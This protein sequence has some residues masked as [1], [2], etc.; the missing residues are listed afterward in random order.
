M[1]LF[2]GISISGLKQH[3]SAQLE[4]IRNNTN[5]Q[6][7]RKMSANTLA[8]FP[9]C[10]TNPN[11]QQCVK[12]QSSRVAWIVAALALCYAYVLPF[13]FPVK[14]VVEVVKRTILIK[15][16]FY[17]YVLL[18]KSYK[19]TIEIYLENSYYLGKHQRSAPRRQ[20]FTS[21]AFCLR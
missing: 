12:Q 6:L 4:P 21:C 20:S 2:S 18:L 16:I 14:I 1:K 5:H 15:H 13:F 17:L 7:L 3:T 11:P 10:A 8:I 19:L 9:F